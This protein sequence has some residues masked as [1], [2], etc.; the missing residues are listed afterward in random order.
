[1]VLGVEI[2]L[3][4]VG[5]IALF[6]GKLPLTQRRFVQGVPAR[7]L[8]VVALSPFPLAFAMGFRAG[9]QAA[10]AGRPIAAVQDSLRWMEVGFVAVSALVVFGIGFLISEEAP[11]LAKFEEEDEPLARDRRDGDDEV[12]VRPFN[13]KAIFTFKSDRQYRVYADAD[14]LYFI[15]LVGQHDFIAKLQGVDPEKIREMDRTPPK[16]MAGNHPHDFTVALTDVA[17]ATIDAPS[18]WGGHGKHSGSWQLTLADGTK[19]SFQFEEVADMRRAIESLATI[20][21][22]KISVNAKWDEAKQKYR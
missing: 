14:Q 21:E 4:I 7:L 3:A 2:A 19:W 17:S 10:D 6:G 12:T 11:S 9:L 5:L 15:H 22:K 16:D 8:G 20:L 18:F 13:A 1:M